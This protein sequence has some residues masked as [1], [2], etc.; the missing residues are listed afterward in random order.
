MQSAHTSSPPT[1]AK[2]IAGT[3]GG[4]YRNVLKGGYTPRVRLSRNT[5]YH[6]PSVRLSHLNFMDRVTQSKR[7]GPAQISGQGESGRRT[8]IARTNS[9]M[10]AKNAVPSAHAPRR[11]FVRPLVVPS[12]SSGTKRSRAAQR[13]EDAV[14]LGWKQH[15]VA[16]LSYESV[17]QRRGQQSRH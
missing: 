14:L 10:F 9:P 3:P 2:R 6:P 15:A 1:N 4:R 17:G 16:D 11:S 7:Q 12:A 8:C 5:V 13:S